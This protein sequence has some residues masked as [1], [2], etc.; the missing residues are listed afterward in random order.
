[1]GDPLYNIFHNKLLFGFKGVTQ[2]EMQFL[3]AGE[4]TD[5]R[6]IRLRQILSDRFDF[7]LGDQSTRDTIISLALDRCFDPVRDMLDKAQGDW[8]GKARLDRMAVDYFNCDD[9]PLNRAIIRKTM[10]AAVRRVRNPGC[11]FDT[12]TVL[13]LPEGWNKSS[14]WRVLAGDDN[15]SDASILGHGAREVQE[16]LSEIWIHENAE[17]A[18]M[19]KAEVETVKTFASRQ[20]DNARPA[21]GHFLKKQKRHSIEVGT[22]NNEEY[23]Q[24]QTGNR[25]FWPLRIRKTIDLNLLERDRLQLWGEAAKYEADG[26]SITL[27]EKLWP[28]AAAEQEKGASRM[29]GKTSSPICRRTITSTIVVA[30]RFCI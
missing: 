29:R 30:L 23:L 2:H 3:V 1:M 14:A 16:Q 6:I 4:V 28:A 13:E 21:Y 27:A 12:I 11:K 5:K 22:T 25:R 10:I 9:T 26:E 20:S 19:K 7:D 15:F 24:S 17:L 18:G 8:D